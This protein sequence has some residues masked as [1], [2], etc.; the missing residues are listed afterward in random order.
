MENIYSAEGNSGT[1]RKKSKTQ[2]SSPADRCLL[3]VFQ[4]IFNDVLIVNLLHLSVHLLCVW[5]LLHRQQVPHQTE[6][7]SKIYILKKIHVFKDCALVLNLFLSWLLWPLADVG[8]T[9]PLG[10]NYGSSLTM[11]YKRYKAM[12]LSLEYIYILT[13]S[14]SRSLW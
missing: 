2:C 13:W 9:C 6:S 12:F 3:C 10:P 4:K 14:F 5:A 8:S 11:F 1:K 7:H